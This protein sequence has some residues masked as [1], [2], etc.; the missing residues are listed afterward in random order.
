VLEWTR[1]EQRKGGSGGLIFGT[2]R[3]R[4]IA[5]IIIVCVC[6]APS[7]SATVGARCSGV[8]LRICT[9]VN[10]TRKSSHQQQTKRIVCPQSLA[11]AFGVGVSTPV[12][13]GH[14][15]R[16][17]WRRR[18]GERRLP[19]HCPRPEG[20]VPSVQHS[21]RERMRRWGGGRQRGA[22]GRSDSPQSGVSQRSH[23][24]HGPCNRHHSHQTKGNATPSRLQIES[25]FMEADQCASSVPHQARV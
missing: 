6:V 8:N 9:R 21:S 12:R 2:Q 3:Q 18:L 20:S 25:R 19:R 11:R 22:Y 23:R 5:A 4:R 24:S 1:Q 10:H 7:N 16:Q 17:R 15:G 14:S 13:A